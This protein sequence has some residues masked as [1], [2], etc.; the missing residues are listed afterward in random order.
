MRI[1]CSARCTTAC[2]RTGMSRAQK[3]LKKARLMKFRRVA[4]TF[5]TFRRV[6]RLVLQ[7]CTCSAVTVYIA[8]APCIERP[9]NRAVT[10]QSP[11]HPPVLSCG[12]A[13]SSIVRAW[14]HLSTPKVV[15]SS[16]RKLVPSL[17]T[18]RPPLPQ[19]HEL[20]GFVCLVLSCLHSAAWRWTWRSR[21]QR[22]QTLVHKPGTWSGTQEC[23][24]LDDGV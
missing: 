17:L 11:L 24:Y 19:I 20:G 7:V 8:Q 5:L 18:P 22:F 6:S 2:D 10:Q 1:H 13:H 12:G 9:S 16:H 4:D 15:V 14:V 3:V 23:S 21:N